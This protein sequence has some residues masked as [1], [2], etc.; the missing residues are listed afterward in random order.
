MKGTGRFRGNA[1]A[2]AALLALAC[3]GVQPPPTA[4]ADQAPRAG[5]TFREPVT[6]DPWDYDMTYTGSSITN[7]YVI[8]RAYSSLMRFKTGPN[9]GYSDA[10]VE[11]LLAQRWEVSSDVTTYTFH[12]RKGVRFA[13]LPPVNPSA[14]SGRA[15]EL[16]AEDVKFTYEYVARSGAFKELKLP[17]SRYAF[18]FEGLE[19]VEAPDPY[20]VAVKFKEPFAPFLNYAATSENPIMPREIYQEDGH[21]KDRIAGTGPFQLDPAA[22]QKG[23]R[24]VLR[25]HPGYFEEGRPYLDGVDLI[26]MK[27]DSVRQ[28]AFKAK[29]V[30]YYVGTRDATV[31]DEVKRAVA[32]AWSIDFTSTPAILAPNFKRPPFDNTKVRLAVSRAL[33]RDE[34]IKVA[35]G[36]TGGWALAFSNVRDD[37]FPQEE[38]KGFVKFNPDEA[39]QLLAEAGF[40]GGIQ[41]EMIYSSEG[42][43]AVVKAAEL[44]Q[45][46]LKKVGINISLKP[47]NETEMTLRRRRF[48]CD[49]CWLSEAQR[50]DLDGQLFLAARSGGASNYNQIADPKADALIGAQRREG[51]PEKRVQVLREVLRYLNESALAIPTY[52]TG[53]AIVIHGHVKDMFANAD[54]RTQGVLFG[55]WLS[56]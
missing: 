52:R 8:K 39:R 21:F 13:G 46:Q 7:P 49:I 34:L 16:T 26:V 44:V 31:S 45:A 6:E 19:S 41:A 37:L 56:K 51:N 35:G 9:V 25:K 2:A 10:V 11:P 42:N 36:G 55:T 24:W 28:A 18:F 29:Q 27:D 5:G 33:D 40:S 23:T 53:Q 20:T 12:L 50:S 14:G 22:S 1:L 3:S 48:D 15:R 47:L 30:D 17:T 4:P 54:Y 38:I 32:G 43:E